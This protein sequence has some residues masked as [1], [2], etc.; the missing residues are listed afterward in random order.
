MLVGITIKTLFALAPVTP[1]TPVTIVEPKPINTIQED[2]KKYSEINN[3][4]EQWLINLGKCESSLNQ[5]SIGDSGH[6][7]GLFQYWDETW[8]RFSRLY[9]VTLDKYSYHDQIRLTA[10]AIANNHGGEWSCDYLTGK[11]RYR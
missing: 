4:P 5:N 11:D 1:V 9:G 8:N 6:A 10:W 3:I 7:V 2:I